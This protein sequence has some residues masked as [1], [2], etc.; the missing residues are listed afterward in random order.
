MHANSQTRPEVKVTGNKREKLLATADNR[1][2]SAM[3][4]RPQDGAK[5]VRQQWE[6]LLD[7]TDVRVCGTPLREERQKI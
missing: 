2:L 1:R 4:G 3:L 5:L 6:K 7:I